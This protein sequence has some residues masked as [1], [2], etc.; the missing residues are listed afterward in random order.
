MLR[1]CLC[2]L[3][4]A[5]ALGFCRR[6]PADSAP[7]LAIVTIV[8]AALCFCSVKLRDAGF[9][10]LGVI[11]IWT[12]SRGMLADRLP[13]ELEGESLDV[14]VRVADFPQSS[15]G[16]VRFIADTVDAPLLPARIRLSWYDA[17]EIPRI[18]ETWRVKMRLR[19]PRGFA[20]PGGFDYELWLARQRIGAT[21][22]VVASPSN[23]RIET[24]AVD[25]RSAL[26]QRL[27]ERIL[28][29]TGEND[30]SAVL[31]AVAVGADH[32]IS[33]ERWED[34]AV[35]GTTHIIAISGLH[36]AL[37]AGGVWLLARVLFSPFC[38]FA[39]VRDLAALAAAVA[40]SAYTE[41]SGSAVPAVRAML[42]AILVT[43]AFLLRRRMSPGTVLA[44][45]CIAILV[46]EPLAIHA[47]GFKLSF[48]AVAI[49]LWCAEQREYET[50][51]I[52]HSWCHRAL[53]GTKRL[54]ALQF[55]LLFGLFPMTALMFG[56]VSWLAPLVNLLVLPLFN[57][58]TIPAAL[59]GLLFDGPLAAAGDGLLRLAWQSVRMMLWLVG[60]AAAWP[61]AKAHTAA[62][63]GVMLPVVL[64]A[65]LWAA[66]PPGFPGRRLAWIAAVSAL[67]YKPP[68]P[69]AGCVDLVALDVGQGLSVVLHGERRTLVFDTGPSFRSGSDAGQLVI[70]PYLRATGTARVDLLVVSHGDDDHAG[71]AASLVE[72]VEVAQIVA[73]E[74][75]A[76]IDRP[77]LRCESGQAWMWDG[78]RFAM[79]HPGLYPLQAG[80]NA[81]CVMEVAVG[82]HRILF[83]G[84]IESPVEN[85]LVRSSSLTPAEIVIVPHHGSRTSSGSSFV[86]ALRPAVAIVSAG[87]AN[88]WGF[89]KEDVV[90]RWRA[91]G[92]R[93]LNTA[94]SGAIHYRLC[95][96]NG[97]RLVGEQRIRQQRYWHARSS[98]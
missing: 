1:I 77:Q 14:T 40:A 58:V 21:G 35:T 13:R 44:L 10:L 95:A 82:P 29:L 97:L 83:T 18:G 34:Y 37:A 54:T 57:L 4:G 8:I 72:A 25:A 11:L 9:V 31:I 66:L 33:R 55:T 96:D 69:P 91:A 50:G 94:T 39:N 98:E 6:L 79:M 74:H 28:N 63:T 30:A 20:N 2:M 64:L 85:H 27:V 3:A 90:L 38:R 15:A 87:Y 32:R 49:L 36:I 81:S 61:T 26:R 17:R 59:L 71:G 75:L 62:A 60:I 68:S 7:I 88:R 52:G 89:P 24:A 19:R 73:G 46:T 43:A 45:S 48:G 78:I 16:A 51:G 47:P 67:L 12:A 41:I 65:A 93:V 80:N 76:S 23:G 84:D 53:T 92:A 22:Y 56:R 70:V 86:N 42:M 5:Y